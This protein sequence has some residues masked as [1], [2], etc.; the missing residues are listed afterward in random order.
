MSASTPSADPALRRRDELRHFLRTRRARLTPQDVGMPEAGRR[1][2]PGLRREEVAVLSGVGVSWYTRLEQGRD[3]NVSGEVLDAIARTLR[4]DVAEREHLYLL[5]GLNPPLAAPEPGA[6]VSG[7]LMRLLDSWSPRPAHIRD[8]YWNLVAVNDVS[9][10]VLGYGEGEH[11][12]LVTFFTSARYRTLTRH[13]AETA[14]HVVG[15]FRKDAA[16]YPDDPEFGRIASDLM[17][18]SPEFAELWERHEVLPESSSV[19]AVVHPE[20]GDLVFEATL[21]GIPEL[22][23]HSLV[24]YNPRPGTGTQEAL[25]R[26]MS[27]V[28]LAAAG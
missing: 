16:H 22:P 28:P 27:S 20:A 7:E 8:R 26:L 11:N 18:V 15:R 17:S 9:A 12:C 24:L 4:M 23:G 25:E 10:E 14:P 1:R 2:T 3:I 6:R 19:K 5:S 13:W 21:L